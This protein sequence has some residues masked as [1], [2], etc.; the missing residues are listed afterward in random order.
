M[1]EDILKQA[2]QLRNVA[3]QL[4]LWITPDMNVEANQLAAIVYQRTETLLAEIRK[5]SPRQ[6]P[7][8]FTTT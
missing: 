3:K 7:D 1:T 2:T 5:V 6:E 8:R 4:D